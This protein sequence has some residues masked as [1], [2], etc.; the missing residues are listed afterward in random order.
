[1]FESVGVIE[2]E[3]ADLLEFWVIEDGRWL[4]H[5]CDR[6]WLFDID[7][8]HWAASQLVEG[9]ESGRLLASQIVSWLDDDLVA[10]VV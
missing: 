3:T 8:R 6:L 2:G 10:L 9:N 5:E 4:V 7:V 1:M